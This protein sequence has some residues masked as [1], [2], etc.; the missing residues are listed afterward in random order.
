MKD[1]YYICVEGEE[2]STYVEA[3]TISQ[4]IINNNEKS[5]YLEYELNVV[6]IMKKYNPNYGDDKLCKCG[7]PYYRHFDSWDGMKP[8]GCKYC[9]CDEFD[10]AE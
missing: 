5:P 3:K 6:G 1:Q 4:S 2:S 7:H 8:V 10:P 9:R